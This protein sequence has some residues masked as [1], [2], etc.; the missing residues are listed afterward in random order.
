MGAF[1]SRFDCN[2]NICVSK[3][4]VRLPESQ[5]L[6][7]KRRVI[8]SLKSRTRNKF[9]VSIAEVEHNES[10][11][12]ATLG[13]AC[14]SNSSRHADELVGAVVDFIENSRDHVELIGHEQEMISGF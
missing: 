7:D 12:L 4:T 3:I 13:I 10:W 9:N 1:A 14:V 11:Q 8:T 5:S 6:K 2:M